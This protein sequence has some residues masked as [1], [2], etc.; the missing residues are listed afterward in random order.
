[1]SYSLLLDVNEMYIVIN[2]IVLN[3]Q[4]VYIGSALKFYFIFD[5]IVYCYTEIVCDKRVAYQNISKNLCLFHKFAN[6]CRYFINPDT[7][8]RNENSKYL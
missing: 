6:N 5:K 7:G 4:I 8:I 2:Y 3:V 1:M